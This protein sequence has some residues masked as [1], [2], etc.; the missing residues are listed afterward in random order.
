MSGAV[1]TLFPGIQVTMA[2]ATISIEVDSEAAKAYAA[3]SVEKRRR[4]DLLLDE[5]AVAFASGLSPD[6]NLIPGL[7]PPASRNDCSRICAATRSR[8]SFCLARDSPASAINVSAC[9]DV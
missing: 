2:T 9:I 8:R 7:G 4:I 3:A 1:A 5:L 6:R